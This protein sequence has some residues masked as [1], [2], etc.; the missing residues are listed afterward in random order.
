MAKLPDTEP[1]ARWNR[2][3][4]WPL[5]VAAILFLVAFSV[6][7]IGNV[8]GAAQ[9]GLLLL[10][11][12]AWLAFTINYV[13]NLVLAGPHRKKWF[14]KNW[15]Q[16]VI[17]AIPAL[18]PLRLLRLV[19]MANFS[20]GT[21][22]SALRGRVGL[23]VS[24]TLVMILYVGALMV[25]D[26]EQNA[27]GATIVSM[28]DAIWWAIVTVTTVGYGDFVPITVRGRIVA[29]GLMLT[30]VGVIGTITGTLASY[31]A[32]RTRATDKETHAATARQVSELSAQIA[33]LE[34]AITDRDA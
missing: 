29:A 5:N 13:A 25:L 32:E 8:Q 2:L 17:T 11:A 4:T 28:G 33:S 10:M 3:A 12:V 30:G 23:Y 34:K 27:P 16:L 14:I 21:K 7:V 1:Q 9:T 22:G 19:N 6:K 31:L 24:S 18:N 20:G 15:Y 26:A